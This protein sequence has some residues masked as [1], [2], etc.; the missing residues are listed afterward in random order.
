MWFLRMEDLMYSKAGKGIFAV[1]LLLAVCSSFN[2][3]FADK[4]YV[5]E[6]TGEYA[7]INVNRT[8][9]AMDSL[10]DQA[11]LEERKVAIDI[12][13]SKPDTFAPPAFYALSHAMFKLGYKD[14][15]SF[16]FYAGQLRARYDANR[17]ADV[18]ARSAVAALNQQYG[19][20]INEYTFANLP[21]L[22]KIVTQLM[23]FDKMTPHNY[24]HRWINLHGMNATMAGM[25]DAKAAKEP[26]S[27]PQDQWEKILE[28]TRSDYLAGF[29]E[30]LEM[31]KAREKAKGH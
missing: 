21:L 6:N 7:T 18:S 2:S 9:G 1:G 3:A 12:V 4:T 20:E 19:Q 13:T 29:A 17:C 10:S 31:A 24:D 26:L 8:R 28:K 27:L 25:G 15:G 22:Q 14:E 30:A 11:P 23:E 16:W 5:I